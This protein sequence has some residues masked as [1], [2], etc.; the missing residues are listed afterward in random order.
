MSTGGHSPPAGM[1]SKGVDA[2]QGGF[3]PQNPFLRTECRA[4]NPSAMQMD[5]PTQPH[6]DEHDPV[7]AEVEGE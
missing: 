5:F 2:E 3:H 7:Y 1:R 4:Q 6:R